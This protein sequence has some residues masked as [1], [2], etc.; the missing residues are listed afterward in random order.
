MNHEDQSPRHTPNWLPAR[1]QGTL[2]SAADRDLD[3]HLI[4]CDRCLAQLIAHVVGPATW[5]VE[6]VP[7]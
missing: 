4:V 5:T 7:A 3:A 2:G 1:L 6:P